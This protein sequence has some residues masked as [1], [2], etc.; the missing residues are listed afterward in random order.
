MLKDDVAR[1]DVAEAIASLIAFQERYDISAR[2]EFDPLLGGDD[3]GR[4]KIVANTLGDLT[5]ARTGTSISAMDTTV[6]PRRPDILAFIP[7]PWGLLGQDILAATF[8][9]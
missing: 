6:L 9:L 3:K 1:A 2:L 5:N 4:W 7:F 8:Q